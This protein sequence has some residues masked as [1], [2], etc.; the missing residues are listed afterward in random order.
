MLVAITIFAVAVGVAFVLYNAAQTSYKEGEQF[1]EQQ[2]TTRVA[3]DRIVEDLRMAGFNYNPDGDIS[4]PDEQVEGAW[5]T[6]V[7]IRGDFDFEVTPADDPT[8]NNVTP[9]T[10]LTGSFNVVSTGNSE[11]VTFALGKPNGTGGVDLIFNADVEE[12]ARD[13]DVEEVRIQN[14]HLDQSSPPYTLYRIILNN[15]ESEYGTWGDFAIKQPIADNIKSLTFR[16]FDANGNQLNTFDLTQTTDDIGGDDAA[17]DVATRADIRRI[18][19]DLVGLTPDPDL[20]Y[21]DTTDAIAATQNYRKFQLTTDV[22]AQNFGLEGMPDLILTAPRMPQN[23]STCDGHCEGII[24]EWD[25]QYAS[26]DAVVGYIVWYGTDPA[27]LDTPIETASNFAWIG[28]LTG[29]PYYFGVQSRNGSEQNSN[30]TTAVTATPVND[31]KPLA[32]DSTSM[33]ASGT[34]DPGHPPIDGR[35]DLGWMDVNENASQGASDAV[36]G[37]DPVR[38]V[39][40]ARATRAPRSRAAPRRSSRRRRR[41]MSLRC[42][43]PPSP[44]MSAGIR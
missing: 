39:N 33:Y 15:D 29:G 26:E 24:V 43:V 23:V 17:A 28:S 9:E 44:S 35:V 36:N 18:E 32:V 20:D 41:P 22:V 11:I 4:R 7:T 30:T 37:C 6:A 42:R 34:V 12:A 16:Y 13:G 27:A 38:P 25:N 31:T 3:F 10:A 5:D 40:R 2:Q 14:I 1:T 21:V 19:V 8:D